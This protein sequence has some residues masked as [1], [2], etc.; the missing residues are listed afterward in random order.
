MARTLAF[1][2]AAFPV[3]AGVAAVCA[4]VKPNKQVA[5]PLGAGL[6]MVKKSKKR[7]PT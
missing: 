2:F 1:R 6:L 5:S 3:L 4:G 7:N